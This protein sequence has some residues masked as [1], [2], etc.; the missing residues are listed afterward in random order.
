MFTLPPCRRS[1]ALALPLVVV[2]VVGCGSQTPAP[3]PAEKPALVEVKTGTAQAGDTAAAPVVKIAEKTEKPPA[4]V[5]AEPAA[6]PKAAAVV[7]AQVKETPK[8]VAAVEPTTTK[9]ALN[10]LDLRTFPKLN[11]DSK[12]D[13]ES[14][15]SMYLSKSSVPSALAYCNA[16]MTSRG[17]KE[18]AGAAPATKEYAYRLFT[19][20]GYTVGLS[21]GSSDKEKVSI[22]LTNH[23][24]VD[25][26]TLAR[27]PGARPIEGSNAI[28]S[29]FH[30]DQE[31]A[32]TT[33]ACRRLL[34][35]A[36]W[37]EFRSFD[38]GDKVEPKAPMRFYLK[39]SSRLMLL[40]S[41]N[42]SKLPGKSYASYHA[43]QVM[44]FDLPVLDD[45][46]DLRLDQRT[47]RLAYRTQ[48]ELGRIQ[49][50]Y[51]TTYKALGWEDRSKTSG[52]PGNEGGR[53]LIF[54]DGKEARFV[55]SLGQDR[56][57]GTRV[58]I[59]RIS[60]EEP[61]LA[62]AEP[63]PEVEAPAARK[64]PGKTKA[65][66]TTR[67]MREEIAKSLGP[68]LAKIK[69][70]TGIDVEKQ[71]ADALKDDDMPKADAEKAPAAAAFIASEKMPLPSS[72]EAVVRDSVKKTITFRTKDD[73]RS[74]ED[75]FKTKLTA[76]GWS[77]DSVS[78]SSVNKQAEVNV[79]FSKDAVGLQVDISFDGTAG[80]G[81]TIVSGEGL[82]F[83]SARAEPAA[84]PPANDGEIVADEAN[85]LPIPKDNAGRS[86]E[87]SPFRTLVEVQTSAGLDAL[88]SFYRKA[89]ANA[90]W[91]ESPPP[92]PAGKDRAAM[93]FTKAGGSLDLS[94]TRANEQTSIRLVERKTE[95]ARKAGLLPLPGKVRLM[96]G[97]GF[98]ADA[99]I[100]INGRPYP[101]AKE[102]GTKDPESAVKIDL[103]PGR[104]K[105]V[106]KLPGRKDQTEEVN[107]AAGDA[108]GLIVVETG[109]V[110]SIQLY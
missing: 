90:G 35:D 59:D 72:A 1:V 10:M 84:A 39:N 2:G 20:D 62:E 4:Q 33:D 11:F 108:W 77:A 22:T 13:D 53:V 63:R 97:N 67:K 60:R 49:E 91:K 47:W 55:V 96:V 82:K 16:E 65:D 70:Q 52:E 19:K 3:A 66:D 41:A 78:R 107:A 93:A 86:G 98:K 30:T 80:H 32:E 74:Q 75:F 110:L 85:G 40:S 48:Q 76:M 83:A 24:N 31:L 88:A 7:P 44:P 18:N 23:G 36:G 38:K 103:F 57:P 95:A 73:A 25:M 8:P 51:R 69:A 81:M 71:V 94:L 104:N 14:T 58:S 54:D 61:K 79:G 87:T 50:F 17:W 109:G 105:L 101:I 43:S 68:D 34:T 106:I 56:E 92:A 42:L 37:H 45:A 12:F 6:E 21:L 28:A 27:P 64:M 9:A 99:V 89:L 15:L 100:E 29:H 26:T 46:T 102:T 5:K